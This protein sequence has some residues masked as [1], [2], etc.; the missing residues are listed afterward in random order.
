[1]YPGG[2]QGGLLVGAP[3][4]DP[5]THAQAG[6]VFLYDTGG[7]LLPTTPTWSWAGNQTGEHVGWSVS[8]AGRDK[9]GEASH[10]G[11]NNI[12]IGAPGYNSNNG[13]AFAFYPDFSGVP[14]SSPS[15][16]VTGS[17]GAYFG[18]AVAWAH[19]VDGDSYADILVGEPLYNGM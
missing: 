12:L 8:D 7:Y 15:W 16:T 6:K 17:S 10:Y 9:V 1:N 4:F 11:F 14:P 2:F 3:Y 19:D 5:G 18:S 13:A